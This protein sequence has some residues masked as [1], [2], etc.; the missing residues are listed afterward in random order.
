VSEE[1]ILKALETNIKKIEG[2]KNFNIPV[3]LKTIEKYEAAQADAQF[4]EAERTQLQK[5]YD[6]I[7]D[8]EA[9][10]ERLLQRLGSFEE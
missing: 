3:I 5:V 7:A 6:M 2:L 10:N 4:I 8:L 1:N 9:R